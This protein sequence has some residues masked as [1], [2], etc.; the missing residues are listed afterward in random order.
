MAVGSPSQPAGA[1]VDGI[2]LTGGAPP[3]ATGYALMGNGIYTVVADG[4]MGF[5]STAPL[6]PD[7]SAFAGIQSGSLYFP[8]AM[9]A[10]PTCLVFSSTKGLEYI[11]EQGGQVK[12]RATLVTAASQQP[13]LGVA[14]GPDPAHGGFA[15]YYTVFAQRNPSGGGAGGGIY[16]VTLPAECVG[17]G[18]KDGGTATDAGV[19]AGPP[20]S[21]ATC[22]TGC[23][24]AANQCRQFPQQT[25]SIC[26]ASG[27]KCVD[28][29]AAG[30]CTSSANG[31]L[32]G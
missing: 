28:C 11:V 8:H 22:P 30:A 19:D 24:D 6:L 3:V 21:P 27:N 16:R 1:R 25:M 13:I 9:A 20:C 4:S 10:A 23:C 5:T 17:A 18:G 15:A 29:G 12:S 32:C 7:A 31:G 14:I 26:G 2:V